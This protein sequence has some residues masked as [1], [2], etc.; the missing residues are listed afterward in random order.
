MVSSA[1]DR[2]EGRR[3][4]TILGLGSGVEFGRDGLARIARRFQHV[5]V[6]DV[7]PK[8]AKKTV[9]E[10][11]ADLRRAVEVQELDV[12]GNVVAEFCQHAQ[13][14]V[15]DS[16]S[17]DEASAQGVAL[18]RRLQAKD[19]LN[20]AHADF[21]CSSLVMTQFGSGIRRYFREALE[22]KFGDAAANEE[23]EAFVLAVT[24]L[25]TRIN[26][27]HLRNLHRWLR[28]GGAAYF[29]DT[30]QELEGTRTRSG[31]IAWGWRSDPMF[32]LEAVEG[33]LDQL[34]AVRESDRWIWTKKQ[35]TA[36][37]QQRLSAYVICATELAQARPQS[38]LGA[39]PDASHDDAA[40][41]PV[42]SSPSMAG[43][44][45]GEWVTQGKGK[46]GAR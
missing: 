17:L 18:V 22:E 29:A 15:D 21:V 26:F 8:T 30:F 39:E 14:T 38:P 2:C 19:V 4:A 45:P 32:S 27:E 40:G 6:A 5:L 43:R 44:D 20:E 37:A 31:P 7:D 11:P 13:R 36:G 41:W 24:R 1:I 10:L 35:R 33:R 28:P 16:A 46:V 42:P 23:G 3:D 9:Q 12:S 25:A 34:F